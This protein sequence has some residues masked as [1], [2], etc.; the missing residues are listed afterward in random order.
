[1]FARLHVGPR[2][3]LLD[4]ACGS[5]WAVRH[6]RSLGAVVSAIDASEALID[7]ARTRNPGCDLRVGSMFELPGRAEE[8][9][10]LV[11]VNGIWGGCE[12]ALVDAHRVLRPG[13]LIGISFWGSGPPLDLAPVSR[14][15]RDMLHRRISRR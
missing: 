5:G 4:M 10:T 8:F 7:V 15:M 3:H 11:S 9:D 13:G 12:H 14:P 1:M 2:R 6:A